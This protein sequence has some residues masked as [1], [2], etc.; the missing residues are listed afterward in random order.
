MNPYSAS[1]RTR[2]E[3]PWKQRW[4]LALCLVVLMGFF[5]GGR[6]DSLWGIGMAG[7]IVRVASMEMIAIR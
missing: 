6:Q 3:R 4:R 7:P 2:E 1:K 5:C